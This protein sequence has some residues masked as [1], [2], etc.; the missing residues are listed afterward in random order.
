MDGPAAI[1]LGCR[2]VE[3]LVAFL[4]SWGQ[5]SRIERDDL[6]SVGR[7]QAIRTIDLK[8]SYRF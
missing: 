2:V 8:G 1:E 3:D 6:I 7:E 5:S 4:L